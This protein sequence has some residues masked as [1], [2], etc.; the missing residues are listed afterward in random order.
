MSSFE[1]R[2]EKLKEAIKLLHRGESLESVKSK[3][4]E[5]LQSINPIEIPAIEQELVKEGLPV[6]EILKLCDLHVDLFRK[7]LESQEL[8]NIPEGHPLQSYLDENE[9]ILKKAEALSVYS[10]GLMNAT[11]EEER[12]SYLEALKRIVS[13][14][15][16]L[17]IHYRKNQMILFPYLERRGI[18]AIPRVLWGKEDQA[19]V[20]IRELEQLLNAGSEQKD[21]S[22]IASL[23]L[24]ISREIADLVFREN[25]ILYPTLLSL[26]SEGEWAAIM[27]LSD[28]L[29][30][31]VPKRE[32]IWKPSSEPVLPYQ[33]EGHLDKKELEKLPAEVRTLVE[34]AVPEEYSIK[35]EGK[36]IELT[37]GFLTK[38]QLEGIF[39]SIPLELT[40]ADSNDR[41]KF[42]SKSKLMGG[43][44]RSRSIIGRRLEYCHPPRLENYVKLNVRLLKEGQFN[45]REFWTRSGD[46]ILRVIVAGIRDKNGRYLGTL[47]IV[48]DFTEI[49]KDPES[50]MKK[51][52]IL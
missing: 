46:R 1:D 37:T 35:E 13:D 40:F 50:I 30:Y 2:K 12:A 49:I 38:E 5:L 10:S 51:I 6:T 41:I 43:F 32:A 27:S 34:T 39:E 17:R 20:K 25:K 11:S 28:E 24:E 14:L 29:G 3:Y 19:I 26:L 7:F 47:E 36:D 15:K 33:I 21:G 31:I 48:E 9:Y 23:S 42:Y 16:K 44:P 45:H 18:N 4:A 52:V 8:K 22:K